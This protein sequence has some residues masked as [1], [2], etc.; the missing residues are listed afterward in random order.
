MNGGSSGRVE[1]SIA[2]LRCS[3]NSGGKYKNRQDGGERGHFEYDCVYIVL[4]DVCIGYQKQVTRP[5]E[6][7]CEA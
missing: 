7:D 1:T 3:D 6:C 5:K 2:V 4:E